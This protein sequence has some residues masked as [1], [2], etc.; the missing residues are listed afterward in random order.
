M[1]SVGAFDYLNVSRKKILFYLEIVA[2]LSAR[3]KELIINGIDINQSIENILSLLL[4]KVSKKRQT[5]ILSLVKAIQYPAYSLDDNYE[6]VANTEKQ[7]LGS[8]ITCSI[9]DGRD[10]EAANCDCQRLNKD[11]F[12][13]KNIIVAAEVTSINTVKTKK[14]KNPGQDMAFIKITDGTGSC[15]VVVFPK[16]YDSMKNMLYEGNTIM[17]SLEQSKN[18]DSVFAKKCWQI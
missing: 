17:L 8:A 2:G 6:W 13:P 18:K 12:L 11:K 5:V 15:D 14:G 7:Y 16:E 10:T 4:P 3:E 1:I 9:I